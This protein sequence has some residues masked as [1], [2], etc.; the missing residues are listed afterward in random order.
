MKSHRFILIPIILLILIVLPAMRI[1]QNFAESEKTAKVEQVYANEE[2]FVKSEFSPFDVPL[3]EELQLYIFEISE[4]YNVPMELILA[5]CGQESNYDPSKIGDEGES[6]GL[7]Q[8]Q[9]KWHK[10]RMEKFNVHEK[11]LLNPYANVLIGVDYLAECIDRFGI[12][13][14]LIA[15]NQG[16]D[17]A[18]AK[19]Q[20]GV[21]TEYAES[22]IYLS[23]NL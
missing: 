19:K 18:V 9:P 5:I 15:Y 16:P 1:N 20:I 23:E 3:H 4:S 8:V 22:V 13:Y 11:D 14:G 2:K 21:I 12:E 17:D 6:Y 7:M 10:E